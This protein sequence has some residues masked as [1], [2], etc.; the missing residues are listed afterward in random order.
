ML[1]CYVMLLC[2]LVYKQY[3][4][5][6]IFYAYGFILI[7]F[8]HFRHKSKTSNNLLLLERS[9]RVNRTFSVS[10]TMMIQVQLDLGRARLG[11]PGDSMIPPDPRRNSGPQPIVDGPK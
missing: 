8:K 4:Y 5:L 3:T 9:T 11:Y 6:F 10:S 1:L 7:H 2:K